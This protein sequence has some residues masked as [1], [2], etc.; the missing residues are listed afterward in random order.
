MLLNLKPLSADFTGFLDFFD[1]LEDC[2]IVKLWETSIAKETNSSFRD[3]IQFI[4]LFFVHSP[5]FDTKTAC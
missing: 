2:P 4:F 3:L 1:S 5:W